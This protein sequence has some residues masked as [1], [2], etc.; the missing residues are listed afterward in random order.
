MLKQ[1]VLICSLKQGI[2]ASAANKT[3]LDSRIRKEVVK[4]S[5]KPKPYVPS[6]ITS[7]AGDSLV[8]GKRITPKAASNNTSNPASSCI[9]RREVQ[10]SANVLHTSSTKDKKVSPS[11]NIRGGPL[12]AYSSPKGLANNLPATL[13]VLT[14]SVQ[15]DYSV[16][17]QFRA[18]VHSACDDFA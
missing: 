8:S 14:R 13:S 1:S 10:C 18:S 5:E 3:K 9:Q 17:I 2:L 6:E 16:C 15:V 11:S 4:P 12:K 7:K